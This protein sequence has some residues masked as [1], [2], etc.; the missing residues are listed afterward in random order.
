[1]N[2]FVPGFL[3]MGVKEAGFSDEGTSNSDDNGGQ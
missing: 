1:M 3:R 2:L